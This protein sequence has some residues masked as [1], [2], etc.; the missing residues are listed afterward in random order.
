ITHI[1]KYPIGQFQIP[2]TITQSILSDWISTIADF[3][4]IIAKE[5]ENLSDQQLDTSYRDEGWTLRQVVHHCADSHMNAF[6]RF[7]LAVTESTPTIK[8]YLEDRW[9]ELVD[10]RIIPAA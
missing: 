10:A 8:P 4:D 2:A 5:V 9:A 3:P 7:K 6:C 1:Q